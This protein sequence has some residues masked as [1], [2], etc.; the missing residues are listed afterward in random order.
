VP[1][2]V[3]VDIAMGE[4]KRTMVG[5]IWLLALNVFFHGKVSSEPNSGGTYERI[6]VR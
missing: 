3:S 4:P 2:I 6:E 5:V 1:E